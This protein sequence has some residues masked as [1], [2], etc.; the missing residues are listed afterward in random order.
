MA[1]RYRR[2]L[3]APNT[4]LR[5]SMSD[6]ATQRTNTILG[7]F[8]VL[9]SRDTDCFVYKDDVFLWSGEERHS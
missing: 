1:T 8:L 6:M 9:D 7:R 4:R 5:L 2:P 3:L